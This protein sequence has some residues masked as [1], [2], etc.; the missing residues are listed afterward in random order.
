MKNRV[1]FIL[2]LVSLVSNASVFAHAVVTEYSLK[3]TPILANRQDQV[4]LTFNSKI[5]LG[6]SQVFLVRKGDKLEPL[7]AEA[8]HKQGQIVVHI[9]ALELGEY[10]LKFKVFAADG[11]LTEDVIHF[12]VSK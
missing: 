4:Q 10:A 11:H 8:G 7:H 9:P 1:L 3:M 6:L 2:M 5:E 12:S